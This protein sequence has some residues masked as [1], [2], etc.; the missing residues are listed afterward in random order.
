MDQSV[1]IVLPRMVFETLRP[2][3][4]FCVGA[5]EGLCRLIEVSLGVYIQF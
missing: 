3:C 1:I 2:E 4:D 5:R